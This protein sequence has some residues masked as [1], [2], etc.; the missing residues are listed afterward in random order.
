MPIQSGKANLQSPISSSFYPNFLCISR[1]H[2][3]WN[4]NS[5]FE[6]SHNENLQSKKLQKQ[7]CRGTQAL[8]LCDLPF[9]MKRSKKLRKMPWKVFLVNFVAWRFK[10]IFLNFFARFIKNGRSQSCSAWVPLQN[11]FWNFSIASF[12]CEN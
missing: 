4:E 11:G 1:T 5:I 2:M 10:G 6:I 7:F 9:F 12:R 3:Y 8:Q